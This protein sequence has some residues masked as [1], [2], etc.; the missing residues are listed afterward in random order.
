MTLA[1]RL[2]V[3]DHG[4]LEQVGPPAEVY[5]RPASRFVAGFLGSRRWT[6]STASGRSATIACRTEAPQPCA[7]ADL[8][9]AGRRVTLGIRPEDIALAARGPG[10]PSR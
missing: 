1:D 10:P 8:G 6:S 9:P 7:G 5:R 4:R 2:A 3:L